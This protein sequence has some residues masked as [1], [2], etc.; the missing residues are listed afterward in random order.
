M[1]DTGKDAPRL[2]FKQR[3]SVGIGAA[4]GIF[5][6]LAE[7]KKHQCWHYPSNQKGIWK[8]NIQ[9]YNSGLC[10]LHSQIPPILHGNFK[11]ANVLVDENFTA[12]VAD[13]GISDVL[14]TIE[15]AGPSSSPYVNSFKDPE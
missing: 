14:D 15:D 13:A 5:F 1:T 3:L 11:T 6:A 9:C 7:K 4:K 12:K 10:Y 8:F 2:E